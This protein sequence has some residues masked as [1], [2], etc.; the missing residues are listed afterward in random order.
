MTDGRKSVLILII[1]LVL[2]IGIHLL[3]TAPELRRAFAGRFGEQPY[4][5]AFSVVAL[6][7]FAL[8]VYGYH[9][10]QLHAGK[11]P[12]LWEPPAWGRHV[13]MALMLPVFPLLIAAYLPGRIAGVIRHPMVTAVKFWALAHLFVRGDLASLLLFLGLMGW[14]V[15]DRISLKHRTAAGL[16]T[17]RSG[18]VVNDVVAIVGGLLLYA[19]FAKW[20]HPLLIGV[21]VVP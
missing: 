8:I 13:T 7:G 19:V 10:V 5:G 4:K 16:V 1:G 2:F 14:A 20:G 18:P 3:P 9:K 12:V 21:G 17:V 15:Y 6:I 11:N